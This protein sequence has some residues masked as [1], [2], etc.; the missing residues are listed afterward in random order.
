[1]RIL[2]AISFFAFLTIGYL[3]QWHPML[4]PNQL[5]SELHHL[6]FLSTNIFRM[7]EDIGELL[8]DDPTYERLLARAYVAR[9]LESCDNVAFAFPE[10]ID[11]LSTAIRLD[12]TYAR[13]YIYRGCATSSYYRRQTDYV[14][15]HLNRVFS[16]LGMAIKLDPKG[17]YTECAY[18]LLASEYA[19]LL[20]QPQKA[21]EICSMAA[22]NLPTS[23]ARHQYFF[24]AS[25]YGEIGEHQKEINDYRM[26]KKLE[27]ENKSDDRWIEWQWK[28][29]WFERLLLVFLPTWLWF[30]RRFGHGQ[31]LVP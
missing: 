25:L 31:A 15:K 24:R 12:P 18:D 2:T 26:A 17:T 1:M 28:L 19:Y 29:R 30:G 4:V 16:D 7:Q 14:E 21:I 11:D 27:L 9:A 10:E 3:Y 20:H 6:D 22:S 8:Q 5:S 23:I 13:A